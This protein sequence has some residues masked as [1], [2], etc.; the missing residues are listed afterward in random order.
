MAEY[1]YPVSNITNIQPVK[2]FNVDLFQAAAVNTWYTVCDLSNIKGICTNIR[3]VYTSSYVNPSNQ[4][5]ELRITIDGN[6]QIL[7]TN[8][9]VPV[10]SR[11]FYH[12]YN[13]TSDAANASKY[14]FEWFGYVYFYNTLKI[15]VRQTQTAIIEM[16]A[17]VDYQIE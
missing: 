2:P 5:L 10:Y 8:K 17:S 9:T 14:A 4:Y 16:S 12:F 11:G 3:T 7:K 13:G 1:I 6:V 15:E